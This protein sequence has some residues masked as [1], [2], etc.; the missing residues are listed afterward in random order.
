MKTL[1]NPAKTLFSTSPSLRGRAGVGLLCLVLCGCV[2]DFEPK[3]IDEV[4]SI[5]VVEGII[6]DDETTITLSRSLNLLTDDFSSS[7]NVNNAKVHVQCD[8][9]TQFPADPWVSGGKYT[10]KT[11]QLDLKR[12]YRLKIEIEEIDS[13][14]PGVRSGSLPFPTKTYE[15]HSVF[16][17]PIKTPEIDSVFWQKRGKGQPVTIHVATHSSHSEIMYYRWS[18][19]E[20]WEYYSEFSYYD[21]DKCP[22]CNAEPVKIGEICRRCGNTKKE[23]PYYCWDKSKSMSLLL[24][25]AEKTV[26]GKITDKIIEYSPTSQRLSY[27]YRIDVT[28]NAISKRAYDYFI[29]IRRNSENTGS[30]F[31]PVPSELRGN[32]VCETDPD[33]PVIGYIDIST[34]TQKRKYISGL[35]IYERPFSEC[36][37]LSYQDYIEKVGDLILPLPAEYI[38]Y[39]WFPMAPPEFIKLH[40]VDCTVYGGT[41]DKPDDWP[42][43]H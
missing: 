15:Y 36:K 34:T 31:A 33:R 22:Q 9:G 37:V 40:C 19:R 12:K 4:S 17:Y 27:L 29:N 35:N 16:S 39:N 3:G 32:I 28:Q 5:L 30:L 1:N 10:I 8:D 24:G 43:N 20:D 18:Y 38:I 25:S 42:N 23:F 21:Q 14:V 13:D 7:T 2:T 26:F 41:T 6:T 11:G